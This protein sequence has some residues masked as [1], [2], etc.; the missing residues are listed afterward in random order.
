MLPFG[1]GPQVVRP[2]LLV[3][4]GL[5][6]MNIIG[7]ENIHHR[8]KLVFIGKK[9]NQG[10]FRVCS[11]DELDDLPDPAPSPVRFRKDHASETVH[12]QGEAALRFLGRLDF[13]DLDD[14]DFSEKDYTFPPA[15][16][17]WENPLDIRL[18]F[19]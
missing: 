4:Q 14:H 18:A 1:D 17:Q 8:K 12:A 3:G 10:A 15:S 19:R 2:A 11:A 13:I 9:R 7:P 5:A 16:G 6:E